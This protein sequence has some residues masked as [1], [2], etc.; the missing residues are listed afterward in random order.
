M[1]LQER[2]DCYADNRVED[3]PPT[4]KI[5]DLLS[6]LIIPGSLTFFSKKIVDSRYPTKDIK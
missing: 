5:N 1:N 3:I 4:E 2:I 6:M